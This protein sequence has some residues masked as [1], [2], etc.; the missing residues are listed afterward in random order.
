MFAMHSIHLS[1]FPV[2]GKF[3]ILF[4]PEMN[5]CSIPRLPGFNRVVSPHFSDDL[6]CL[7]LIVSAAV[8]TVPIDVA[9][10]V[11]FGPR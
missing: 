8:E 5:E 9:A 4:C 2:A 6:L 10:S 1:G 3:Q 7:T 11:R